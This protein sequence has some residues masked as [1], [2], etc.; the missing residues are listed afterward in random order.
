MTGDQAG[1]SCFV[2]IPQKMVIKF[3]MV[4][5]S[6][7]KDSGHDPVETTSTVQQVVTAHKSNLHLSTL[8]YSMNIHP[9]KKRTPK[10]K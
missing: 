4:I 9:S 7:L 3:S 2:N 1:R 8:C 6:H 10:I 5:L